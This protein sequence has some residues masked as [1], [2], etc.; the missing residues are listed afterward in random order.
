[1]QKIM[2]MLQYTYQKNGQIGENYCIGSDNEFSNIDIVKK[3]CRIFDE[4]TDKRD[5]QDLISFV[6]DRKGH[7]FRYS[8]D[9]NKIQMTG[10]KSKF[11]FEESLKK[12]V[13]WY[14]NNKHFLN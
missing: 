5:S 2:L 14:L 8:V 6:K 7:D 11:D 1:M 10:W 12:T 4:L 13:E 3:T 9:S